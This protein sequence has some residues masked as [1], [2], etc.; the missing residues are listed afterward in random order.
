VFLAG[1]PL[2]PVDGLPVHVGGDEGMGGGGDQRWAH[3]AREASAMRAVDCAMVSGVGLP[4]WL[5]PGRALVK[6]TAQ[7]SRA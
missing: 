2:M 7:N 4:W 5:T 3:W 6:A 1:D